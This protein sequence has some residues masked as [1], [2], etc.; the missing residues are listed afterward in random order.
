MCSRCGLPIAVR[1]LFAVA[2]LDR[3]LTST[4]AAQSHAPAREHSSVAR[5]E[6]PPP[7]LLQLLRACARQMVSVRT[8]ETKVLLRVSKCPIACRC[9]I[10]RFRRIALDWRKPAFQ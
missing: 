1:A 7:V 8:A 5:A 4:A 6:V 2:S 10:Y 9:A 3:Q